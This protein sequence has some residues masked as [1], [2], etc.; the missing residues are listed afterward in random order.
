M[1]K[2]KSLFPRNGRTVWHGTEGMWFD[3]KWDPLCDL[4]L[5]SHP[6][7]WPWI[8]KIKYWKSFSGG[9]GW[10]VSID[11]A[12]KGCEL[13]K[14]WTHN[15][16][17]S[18]DLILDFNG[19]MLKKTVS[20]EWWVHW[21]GTKRMWVDNIWDRRWD[22][23]LCSWPWTFKVKL[24]NSC[25][26]RM[27]GPIDMEQKGCESVGCWTH[28]RT[29]NFNPTYDLWLAV[30]RL[31]FQIVICQE[32]EGQLTLDDKDVRLILCWT[33]YAILDLQ[34]GIASGIQNTSNTLTK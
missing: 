29:L 6:W 8:L 19:K 4:E 13:I 15:V 30:S 10:G 22:L 20:Q 24:W 7:F 17:L 33:P 2:F 11:M 3:R 14:C 28:C 1:V 27:G 5:W 21:H 26:S 12:W 16:N 32:W 18:Y 31:N 34:Y 25:I 23:G 9:W